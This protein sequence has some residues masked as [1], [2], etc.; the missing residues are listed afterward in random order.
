MAEEPDLPVAST[1]QPPGMVQCDITGQWVPE[2]ETITLQGYRVGA[3]G[4]VELLER[5]RSGQLAPGELEPPGI[6]RRLVCL[7]VDGFI[8]NVVSTILFVLATGRTL[9]GVAAG[10][11]GMAAFKYALLVAE[12]ATGIVALAYYTLGHGLRGQTLGKM[13]GSTKVVNRDGS[14]ISMT[15]AFL[16]ALYY[17]GPV[18]VLGVIGAVLV[19]ADLLPASIGPLAYLYI[20][21]SAVMAA[22]D[23]GQQ[24]AI[25]DRLAGTRVILLD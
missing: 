25:H 16:R 23:S 15:T 10:G 17:Y 12:L 7:M 21:T 11:T 6:F 18:T 8:L 13:A 22:V 19:A 4:K 2:H 20:L 1:E 14:D 24:L 3:D 5:L 9:L